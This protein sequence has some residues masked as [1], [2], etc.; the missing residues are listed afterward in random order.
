M[1]KA[2][3]FFVAIVFCSNL[4]AQ[5]MLGIANSNY[6]GISGIHMNPST[7]VDSRLKID[8]NLVSG[9]TSFDNDYLYIPKEDLKFFGFQNIADQIDAGNYKEYDTTS[10][11]NMTFASMIIGPSVMFRVKDNSFAVTTAVR[12]YLSIKDLSYAIAKFAYEDDALHYKPQHGRSYDSGP[13]NIGSMFWSELGISYGREIMSKEK[14]YLKGALTIKRLWGYAAF[15]VKGDNVRF[16]VDEDSLENL[17]Y[18]VTADMGYGHSYSDGDDN[19][20][21]NGA[22][23]GFDLGLAYEYRPD[24][25]NSTYTMDGQTLNNPQINKYKLRIGLSLLDIGKINFDSENSKALDMRGASAVWIDNDTNEIG[26]AADFDTTISKHFF[27][28][29]YGSQGGTAF[30]MALPTALS[31]QADYM[32]WKDI[33][34]NATWIQSLKHSIPGVERASMISLTPRYEH[35]WFEAALPLSLYEYDVF[36]MGLALRLASFFIGSDKL[37]SVLGIND[38]GGMDFYIGLK[39]AVAGAKIRDKD[40]DGVS[41]KRDLC[42]DVF[43]LLA[44]D[45]CPDRD[46]DGIQDSKDDC[47]DIAGLVKFKGCPDH[48]GDDVED[49]VDQC[50]DV[51]GLVEFS[52]CPDFDNDK[53]I[54]SLDACPRDSGLAIFKG[55][56]DTD[57]DS[58]PDVEDDCPLIAGP[59]SNKG[60]PKIEKAPEPKAPVVVALTQE[61]KEIINKVFKNLEFETGKAVIRPSSFAS[62]DELANLLSRKTMYKLNIDGHTDNVGGKAYNQKLSDSRANAVKKYLTGKGIDAARITAKGYGLTRPIASNKT[63]EGRQ[64]N[65]RVEFTI[66]E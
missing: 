4:F 45:G 12:A 11:K 31:L 33:Y 30:D 22:G 28:T 32:A 39:F 37:G 65:R 46:G 61:E 5:E 13:L 3:L 14:N 16:R 10:N 52:G 42:P 2:I 29:P 34:I 15:Y 17:Y 36:R 47:P 66:V 40:G 27:G 56:P 24:Y 19:S 35:N 1:K 50:P 55:C 62:L 64:R 23:W 43:G 53:I 25:A 63:P 48:D 18:Q 58:I 6:A 38:L 7:I 41:D 26:D 49:R 44:F 59:V 9:G 8:I 20:I 21:V 54:D 60:C 51:P 57:G